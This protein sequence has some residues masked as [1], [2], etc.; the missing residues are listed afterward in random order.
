MRSVYLA[1]RDKSTRLGVEMSASI[2]AT[3]R[4][5][6]TAVHAALAV[7]IVFL[8]VGVLGFIPG[9]PQ[10]TVRF[11]SGPIMPLLLGISGVDLGTECGPCFS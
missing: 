2:R 11:H 7:A 5:D 8:A 4:I 1:A 9:S 6:R 10:T 3:G